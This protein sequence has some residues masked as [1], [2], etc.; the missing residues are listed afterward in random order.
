MN[1]SS[2]SSAGVRPDQ[3][4]VE[5]LARRAE[6]EDLRAAQTAGEPAAVDDLCRQTGEA[7]GKLS[8]VLMTMELDGLIQKRPGNIYER[9]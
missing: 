2:I 5:I 7:M 4:M 9:S 3:V 8:P 1:L 6:H